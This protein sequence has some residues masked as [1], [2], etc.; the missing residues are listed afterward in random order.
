MIKTSDFIE[1]L[2]VTAP[3]L[4]FHDKPASP[5]PDKPDRTVM[6]TR[7]PGPG[8]TMD[9]LFD[10]PGFSVR[11]RGAAHDPG[12]AEDDAHTIDDAIRRAALPAE[13]G[14]SWVTSI[15][16]FGGLGPMPGT[17]DLGHRSEWVATFIVTASTNL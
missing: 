13:I 11:V 9:G 16:R 3:D 10:R 1:W 7:I 14:D 5:L 8:E 4:R 17:P 15:T 2:S 6:V 12:S